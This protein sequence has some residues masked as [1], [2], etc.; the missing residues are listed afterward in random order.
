MTM[1]FR[2]S[3]GLPTID[4]TTYNVPQRF[5]TLLGDDAG[6]RMVEQDNLHL[7]DGPSEAEVPPAA[8]HAL[9]FMLTSRGQRWS[10]HVAGRPFDLPAPADTSFLIPAG[11]D[12]R[13]RSRTG[14]SRVLHVNVDPDWLERLSDEIGAPLPRSALTVRSRPV[15][16]PFAAFLRRLHVALASDEPQERLFAEHAATLSGVE[17]IRVVRQAVED[18]DRRYAIAPA[19]LRRVMAYIDDHLAGDL[20]LAEIASVAALSRFHFARAFRAE[21]GMS[22]HRWVTERRCEKAKRLMSGTSLSLAEVA[23]ACGFAHQAHFT[24]T[25]RRVV[26]MPPGRWRGAAT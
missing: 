24:N 9:V 26:G 10:G 16:L 2:P 7:P 13:W 17:L 6:V 14:A 8:D 23:V 11:A 22:P 19:R 12:A 5:R 3:T 4:G 18:P 20:G 21:T 25:F 1:R 15:D